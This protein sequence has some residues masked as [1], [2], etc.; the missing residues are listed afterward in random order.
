MLNQIQKK[1]LYFERF[2]H[3]FS[4]Y[5]R[6]ILVNIE[7]ICSNQF[8][9]CRKLLGKN[10]ILILGK[11]KIVKKVLKY[12]IKNNPELNKLMPHMSGNIGFIFTKSSPMEIK[13]ILIDN[14]EPA[15]AKAGQVA[16]DDVVIPAG[17]T[18]ITPDGTSFFQALNIQTKINKG[19]IEIQ[20]PVKI[21]SKGDLI[22]NSEVILLQKLN[23]TPFSYK[24]SI[25]LV[26]ENKCCISPDILDISMMDIEKI[27]NKKKE[28]LKMLESFFYYPSEIRITN[29]KK[30]TET[31]LVFLSVALGYTNY[32]NLKNNNDATKTR[33]S[34]NIESV[35]ESVNSENGEKSE[36]EEEDMG[37][38]LFD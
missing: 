18:G 26:Y 19:L 24:L 4:K 35:R 2:N 33:N 29:Q 30:K 21:I 5:S 10:S 34:T 15:Q 27:L 12:H 20:N 7:N 11:N 25:K 37:L 9:K 28:D 36:T 13:K 17:L 14:E 22:G 32:S 31:D 3:L 23:I 6:I 16:P 38:G 1:T 8:K